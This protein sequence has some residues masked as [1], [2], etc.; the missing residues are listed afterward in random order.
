MH[1]TLGKGNFSKVK[2]AID[3]N[4]KTSWAIKIVDR[5]MI[6]KEN[7]ESQLRRE[8]AIMK[9]LKHKHI[10][11]LREV[12][13]SPTK[14][15]IVLELVTGGELFD[16]IVKQKRFDEKTSRNYFQQLVRGI[17]YCHAQDVS[18]RDLK[19]ENL[20]LDESDVLK[21]SDFGLSA[22][23]VGQGEQQKMLMTTCGTPNYV[24]RK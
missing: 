11:K 8:I 21:I 16:R 15:Y 3:V 13:Q 6:Q 12:L 10:I 14:I 18:H 4:D 22:L 23:C 24:A 2:Y 5:K 17:A 19:P 1:Q 20:L 7:L 9:L